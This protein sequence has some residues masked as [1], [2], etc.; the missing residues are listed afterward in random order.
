MYHL[1]DNISAGGYYP[2]A[3][4]RHT[5]ADRQPMHCAA[6]SPV[7]S[8]PSYSCVFLSHGQIGDRFGHNYVCTR[9]QSA[10]AAVSGRMVPSAVVA[11]R[12]MFGCIS[13]M[14]RQQIHRTARTF[15]ARKIARERACP[16]AE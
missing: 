11:G 9:L 12:S 15:T 5:R 14:Q 3:D 13:R 10:L 4:R 16:S 1:S 6:S 7:H 8:L 2:A